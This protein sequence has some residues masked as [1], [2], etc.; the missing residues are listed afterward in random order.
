MTDQPEDQ[1]PTPEGQKR[2]TRAYRDGHD[3]IWGA[4]SKSK[5]VEAASSQP[6]D[7][8]LGPTRPPGRA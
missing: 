6:A 4:A 3:R 7:P 5:G 2:V 8:R 1:Q